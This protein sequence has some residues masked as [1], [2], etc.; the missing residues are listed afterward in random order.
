MR[1]ARL[2]SLTKI[3][4]SPPKPSMGLGFQQLY[5]G[6][7]EVVLTHDLHLHML[8]EL[9]R[10]RNRVRG[11]AVR[12]ATTETPDVRHAHPVMPSRRCSARVTRSEERRV[13]QGG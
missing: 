5:Y 1:I 13:G 11:A 6:I 12:L 4:P 2:M 3:R 9:R 8:G 10:T 7:D